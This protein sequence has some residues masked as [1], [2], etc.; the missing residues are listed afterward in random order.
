VGCHKGIRRDDAQ[1]LCRFALTGF[2][3][4]GHVFLPCGTTY[5]LGC[6]RVGEP[7]RSRLP[8]GRGL[9]YPRLHTA[10]PFICEA[11][12]VR[13]Q[14]GTELAKSGQHLGL[15]MLERM[16]LIDQAN[17]WSRGTHLIY[18]ANL[19]RLRRFERT[20]GF[21]ILRPTPLMHPPRDP[22][23]GVMWAQQHYLLQTPRT[24]SSLSE[25]RIRFGT[26]RGLRSAAAQYF[27]WDY[28]LAHPERALRDPHTR[29]VFMVDRVSPTDALGY[30]MMAT[31]MAKRVGDH[32]R[33][34]IA[35]T[36]PQVLWMV[37]WLDT[38]WAAASSLSDRQDTAAAAVAHLL[39]WLGWLRSSETFSLCWADIEITHPKD[40]PCRGLPSGVGVIELRLL[41][42]T[43][44]NRTRVADVVI[45][46]LCASGLAP[47]LWFDRL[48]RLWPHRSPSDPVLRGSDG[49]PWTSRSFR[50]SFLYPWLYA[51][52]QEG[53]PFLQ[54]FSRTPGNRIEDK[55]YS[56]GSYRRGGRTSSTRRG[57]GTRRASE[58][59]VYEH[60]RWRQRRTKENM[61]TLYTEFTL[62]D[63][64]NLT[65]LCM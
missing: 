52:R 51:M 31:G 12:T 57:G 21:G 29:K 6:I 45:S 8:A 48:R 24:G 59:E 23:I 42:E 5:H 3:L 25:D 40:G 58:D 1:H 55:Y 22:S 26:A 54:A 41:P 38:R 30:G 15:L 46:Y 27:L 11:C 2:P 64:L 14:I 7:F 47:G 49:Q 63:R 9:S 44:S 33:P 62:M 39:L 28:V 32:S 50:Q 20:F 17:A 65:L 36:P 4:D 53:D 18:Q 19:G 61:P 10:P 35:L 13:A 60:G 43:K 16:R 56:C 34:P 37:R